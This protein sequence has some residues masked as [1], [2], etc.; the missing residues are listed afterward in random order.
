MVSVDNNQIDRDEFTSVIPKHFQEMLNAPTA[1]PLIAYLHKEMRHNISTTLGYGSLGA[2]GSGTF[3]NAFSMPG[4]GVEKAAL[5]FMGLILTLAG[6][7]GS[8]RQI[9]GSTLGV[10]RPVED[11]EKN[12]VIATVRLYDDATKKYA[13]DLHDLR[14]SG[15]SSRIDREIEALL[16]TLQKYLEDMR[17]DGRTTVAAIEAAP[18]ENRMELA[19]AY[20]ARAADVWSTFERDVATAWDNIKEQAIVFAAAKNRSIAV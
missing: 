2:L 7:N 11:K 17:A 10:K 5:F 9:F 14:K 18:R 13:R 1:E 8:C 15:V 20:M 3:I 4:L 12:A 16:E 6:I 19:N